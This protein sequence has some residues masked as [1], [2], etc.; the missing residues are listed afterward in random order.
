MTLHSDHNWAESPWLALAMFS[1]P[2][3][4][5]ALFVFGSRRRAK[6]RGGEDE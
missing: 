4:L 1:M 2:F 3:V 6:A 5:F